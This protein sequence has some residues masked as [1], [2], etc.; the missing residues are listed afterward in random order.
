V[1]ESASPSN[2][3]VDLRDRVLAR[4]HAAHHPSHHLQRNPPGT[5]DRLRFKPGSVLLLPSSAWY[6]LGCLATGE[7]R[8]AEEVLAALADLQ[9]E[10]LGEPF[11]GTFPIFAGF[12]D[13]PTGGQALMWEEYDPNWR[14]FLGCMLEL[15]VLRA[16]TGG[17]VG[18][19]A[20]DDALADQM[21]SVSARA[22]T[23]DPDDRVP[24]GYSNIALMQAW[25]DVTVGERVGRRSLVERGEEMRHAV[26]ERWQGHRAFD[27]FNSPTYY[28]VLLL[29]LGLWVDHAPTEAFSQDGRR[30]LAGL[31]EEIATAYHPRLRNLCGPYFRAY[32]LDMTRYVAA[33][34]LW[35]TAAGARP[36]PLP[37]LDA[38]ELHQG[39]DLQLGATIPLFPTVTAELAASLGAA[40]PLPRRFSRELSDERHVAGHLE[41][42]SMF[43][44]ESSPHDWDAWVQ[45]TG[46]TGHWA[47]GDEVAWFVLRARGS[48]AGIPR[49]DGLDLRLT[50]D[51][52]AAWLELSTTV[53]EL[54]SRHL[55]LGDAGRLE[56]AGTTVAGISPD[57]RVLLDDPS[58]V[59]VSLTLR[60]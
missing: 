32:G 26:M 40:P 36:E 10:A 43:G 52:R 54:G 59:E 47:A 19:P 58:G 37:E 3:A 11:D 55:D 45:F 53:R 12:P 9:Y 17:P 14:Q 20:I 33:L 48:L 29:A 4:G 60:R 31:A 39:H 38:A 22:A 57:G 42:E 44:V 50:P 30:L 34:G 2:P 13:P 41:Q 21:R 7:Q 27:E 35:L 51:T 25:H 18:L 46:A 16:G 56:I 1:A 5:Y 23:S 15:V 6:A 28:G 49:A 24:P 8:R